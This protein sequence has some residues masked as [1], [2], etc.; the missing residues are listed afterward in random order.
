MIEIPAE[1]KEKLVPGLEYRSEGIWAGVE[2]SKSPK[3]FEYLSRDEFER[4]LKFLFSN[5]NLAEP[6]AEA[7]LS[8]IIEAVTKTEEEFIVSTFGWIEFLSTTVFCPAGF[9]LSTRFPNANKRLFRVCLIRI[10]GSK[11]L[12]DRMRKKLT[13]KIV[14]LKALAKK[15]PKPAPARPRKNHLIKLPAI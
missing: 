14:S 8:P 1:L 15:I 3:I 10:L 11:I 12:K 2:F 4:F 6:E 13:E 9:M 5:I 7:V